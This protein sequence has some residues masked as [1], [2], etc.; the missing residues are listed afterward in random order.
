M[1]ICGLGHETHDTLKVR[2]R[3]G[4]MYVFDQKKYSNNAGA[5]CPGQD[6]V[7][8][9]LTIEGQWESHD[10]K[11]IKKIL[12]EGDTDNLVIDF[13]CH[14]GWYTIM[15]AK[16]G[17]NVLA[18]DGDLENL[19]LLE[20]NAKLH[21]VWDKIE[22]I[23]TWVDRNS[24]PLK[25]DDNIELVKMDIEGNEEHALAMCRNILS[26]INNLYVEIS[27]A[28]NDSYPDLVKQITNEGFKAYYPDNKK[29]DDDFSL[30]QINLRFSR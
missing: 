28:F 27:P 11:V 6:A 9:N 21:N 16:M 17:Y 26:Q 25:L 3:Q 15:A 4:N 7:S 30:S 19:R 23:Y 5:Y 1:N 8:E 2:T 14:I 24:K 10:S 29:F 13:G 22:T 12:E 20:M 18:I